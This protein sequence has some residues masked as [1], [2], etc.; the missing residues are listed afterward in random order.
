[1]AGLLRNGL[2]GA[3]LNAL[4]NVSINGPPQLTDENAKAVFK[5][6]QNIKKRRQVTKQALKMLEFEHLADGDELMMV[7]Q[8]NW[9]R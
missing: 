8:W 7:A 5:K 6:W 9:F 3:I 1:M 2:L 4:I